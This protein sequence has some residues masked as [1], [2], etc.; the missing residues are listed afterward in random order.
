MCN[1][2]YFTLLV[3][4]TEILLEIATAVTSHTFQHLLLVKD[5]KKKNFLKTGQEKILMN[6]LIDM[7]NIG[8]VFLYFTK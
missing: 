7:E 3:G 8:K 5:L 1:R 4:K 2:N 6:H